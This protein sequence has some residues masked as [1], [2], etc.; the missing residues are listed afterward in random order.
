MGLNSFARAL[1]LHPRNART[2]A[3]ETGI[4][5]GPLAL[6]III[7]SFPQEEATALTAVP[8]LYALFIVII[9]TLVTFI[10]WRANTA[11]EQKLPNAML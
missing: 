6:A 4:Q 9:A 3:L 10:F 2:V 1:K 5:N 7:F 11:A 8:V